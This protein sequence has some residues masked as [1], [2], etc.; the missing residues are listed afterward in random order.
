VVDGVLGLVERLIAPAHRREGIWRRRG[1][2]AR[3]RTA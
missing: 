3:E 2:S 1:G